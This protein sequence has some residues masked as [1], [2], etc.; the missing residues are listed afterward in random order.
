MRVPRV[1]DQGEGRRG[2]AQ[3]SRMQSGAVLL[4]DARHATHARAQELMQGADSD[5]RL[6]G[7]QGTSRCRHLVSAVQGCDVLQQEAQ[8]E[9]QGEAR[10]QVRGSARV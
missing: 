1:R 8:G 6:A 9:A 7:L 2:P 5:L 3:V 4:H 10:E